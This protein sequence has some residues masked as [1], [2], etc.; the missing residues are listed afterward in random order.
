MPKKEETGNASAARKLGQAALGLFS[1]AEYEGR[2]L[3]RGASTTCPDDQLT[4]TKEPVVQFHKRRKKTVA[5]TEVVRVPQGTRVRVKRSRT[6]EHTVEVTLRIG[7]GVEVSSGVADILKASIR[8]EIERSHS[9]AYV[10]RESI[11]YEVEIDGNTH[12]EYSL[13]WTDTWRTGRIVFSEN[14]RQASTA[15]RLRESTELHVLPS[16]N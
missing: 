3:F 9:K 2:R 10:E 12:T 7:E 16:T 13:I 5:A 1:L 11:E 15:F 14:G 8:N 4:P 6:L